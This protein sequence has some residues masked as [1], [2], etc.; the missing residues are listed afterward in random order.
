MVFCHCCSL[1]QNTDSYTW[2]IAIKHN[3]TYKAT[4]SVNLC[5]FVCFLDSLFHY[6]ILQL[7]E[8]YGESSPDLCLREPSP[9]VRSKIEFW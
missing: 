7:Q 1:V 2:G 5:M 6:S 4:F 9:M 3:S 8:L